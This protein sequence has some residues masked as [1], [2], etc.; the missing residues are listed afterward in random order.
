[1]RG[2]PSP[3]PTLLVTCVSSGAERKLAE[4][5]SAMHVVDEEVGGLEEQQ[6][7]LLR[8]LAAVQQQIAAAKAKRVGCTT[9]SQNILYYHHTRYNS[10]ASQ[11]NP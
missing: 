8:Q 11:K 7:E 9:C 1:M 10:K 2:A 4:M 3:L 5:E 6:A